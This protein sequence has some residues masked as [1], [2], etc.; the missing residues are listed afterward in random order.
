VSGEEV[1]KAPKS[2]LIESG[3]YRPAAEG[4]GELITS[5]TTFI[6]PSYQVLASS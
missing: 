1:A 6:I 2:R 5:I 3:G 4:F